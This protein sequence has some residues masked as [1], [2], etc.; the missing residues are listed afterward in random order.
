[1]IVLRPVL[2]RLRPVI[3]GSWRLARLYY[4]WHDIRLVGRPEDEVWY[5][6][7]GANMHD[8]AFRDRRKMCPI[9]WRAGRV[10]G[11]RLRFNLEGRP[12]GKDLLRN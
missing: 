8:S 9:E 1:M 6:A 4:G 7:F 12:R 2:R 11:Y 10:K 5:F 3:N